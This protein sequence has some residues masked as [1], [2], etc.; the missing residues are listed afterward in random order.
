MKMDLLALRCKYGVSGQIAE[1]PPFTSFSSII[2]HRLVFL[3]FPLS[4]STSSIS[5]A[6]SI[7]T[8]TKDVRGL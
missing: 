2:I 7:H 3:T 1:I 4:L 5:Y 6:L 8:I